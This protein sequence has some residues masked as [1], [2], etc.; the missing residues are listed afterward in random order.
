[1]SPTITTPA[2]TQAGMILGTA[3]YM[4]P[5][6]A[7]GKTVD[8]RADIWAFGAVLFEMLT[9]TPGVPD[10]EDSSRHDRSRRAEARPGLER[11]AAATSARASAA[12]R[13]CLQK[14]PKRA[15]ARHS[16][17]C[18]WRS[19]ARSR[20]RFRTTTARPRT[21]PTSAAARAL[22]WAV[23]G[24]FA[25]V[26]MLLWAPWRAEK[27]VDRPLVRLDVDLGADVSLP[28]PPRR[29]SSV[30]IS[31]DG[32][33]LVYAS[34]TPTKLFTRRLDQP[35]ATELPGT[36]GATAPFFSPDGQW[37]GF[38]SGGKLNKISVEGGA[39]VPLGD[40]ANFA[41]AS[42]G[43]DGSI[44]V[45]DALGK[46]LLRIPA[47]GGP[48]ETVAGLGNG[49]LGLLASADSARRQSDPVCG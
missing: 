26:A 22:P 6:Q 8:K 27:P 46:G 35:K 10:G 31:P 20:P 2:M 48:P 38:V 44:L 14:D 5:E 3:A 33:R 9:G 28:A 30:A 45:S 32:T 40:V 36:Q 47:G 25:V 39:V 19:R 13:R 42:W 1:M 11:A 18:A 7:R 43:E 49:E 16:A 23:A 17:T 12:L 15:P 21:R 34:G 41:G 37:V 24:A 4:T 29:R